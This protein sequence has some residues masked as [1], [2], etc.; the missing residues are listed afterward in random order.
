MTR[1]EEIEALKKELNRG[2]ISESEYFKKVERLTALEQ[3]QKS[4]RWAQKHPFLK[5]VLNFGN[6]SIKKGEAPAKTFAKMLWNT[7]VTVTKIGI[8]A[9]VAVPSAPALATVGGIVGLSIAGGL[10]NEYAKQKNVVKYSPRG[11]KRSKA[12]PLLLTLSRAFESERGIAATL[13]KDETF[14]KIFAPMAIKE[15]AKKEVLNSKGEKIKPDSEY[16]Y[17]TAN[18]IRA[19]KAKAD[20]MIESIIRSANRGNTVSGSGKGFSSVNRGKGIGD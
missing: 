17:S 4:L 6:V 19:R 14:G 13:L 12:S 7:A 15:V 11:S 1:E 3:K 20:E 2:H 9:G 18:D 16:A 8:V 5:K 10:K